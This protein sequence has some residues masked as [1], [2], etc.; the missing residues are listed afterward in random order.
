MLPPYY[1]CFST[2]RSSSVL[3]LGCIISMNIYIFN[4]YVDTKKQNT[5]LFVGFMILPK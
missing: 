5:L 2:S 3:K 4:I 1:F